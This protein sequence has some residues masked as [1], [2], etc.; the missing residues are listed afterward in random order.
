MRVRISRVKYILNKLVQNWQQWLKP[1][2]N[3]TRMSFI[4]HLIELLSWFLPALS[5]LHRW[6]EGFTLNIYI[7]KYSKV[8]KCDFT[9][10]PHS[11]TSNSGP[12]KVDPAPSMVPLWLFKWEVNLTLLL[13]SFCP[14]Y[15]WWR[16]PCWTVVAASAVS[17]D[18]GPVGCGCW[19]FPAVDVHGGVPHHAP[20]HV[21]SLSGRHRGLH[22]GPCQN[23][24][25]GETRHVVLCI[26][27]Q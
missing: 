13:L 9:L 11:S 21:W 24:G 22:P 23:L 20:S 15:R 18:G 1:F 3:N 10:I 19:G 14:G 2:G 8:L 27:P 6:L 17:D 25:G 26:S 5:T 7:S 12:R 4:S 16:D